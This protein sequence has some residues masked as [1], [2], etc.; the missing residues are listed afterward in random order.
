MSFKSRD[1]KTFAVKTTSKEQSEAYLKLAELNGY[2]VRVY[3]HAKLNCIQGT[4]ILPNDI[5]SCTDDRMLLES[6]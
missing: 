6:L 5:E 1:S 2:K 3:P 4:V